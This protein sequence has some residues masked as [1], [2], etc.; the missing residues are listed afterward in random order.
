MADDHF[1]R[2]AGLYAKYRP[3]YPDAVFRWLAEQ[4]PDRRRAWDSATGSG[5][6][7]IRLADYFTEV[8][9]TDL[10]ARQLSRARQHPSVRYEV[11]PSECAPI[12]EDSIDLVLVAQ[13]LHWFD[14]P[15]FYD[16]VRR[17]GR[18]GAVLAALS[19]G[20][21]RIEPE[22]DSVIEHLYGEVLGEYW[23]RERVHVEN[24]YADLPF[25]FPVIPTPIF[26]MR[27][28][29][30][31]DQLLGYLGSWSAVARYQDRQGRN[32]LSAIE[33]PL[34]EAWGPAGDRRRIQWPLNVRAGRVSG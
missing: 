23:P 10:S 27:A 22:I 24:A 16:E 20:L 29:W 30:D 6:A 7:A 13:A 28:H 18:E 33:Q 11:A 15:A 9:A 32:P 8:V 31:L 21:L 25:P 2:Q 26:D 17:V 34:R 19:Y 3:G 12:D 1:S 14:L 4:A 5:Q